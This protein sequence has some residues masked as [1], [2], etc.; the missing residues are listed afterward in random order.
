[1]GGESQPGARTTGR[2]PAPLSP[3]WAARGSLSLK[4][5]LSPITPLSQFSASNQGHRGGRGG[6]EAPVW[7]LGLAEAESMVQR[8]RGCC[9]PCTAEG[10]RWPQAALGTHEGE[11]KVADT[12]GYGE[13]PQASPRPCRHEAVGPC[14]IL[15]WERPVGVSVVLA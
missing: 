11:R 9:C 1:M 12:N 3:S 5:V 14:G 10:T 7:A 4:L 15:H 13:G 6:Y 2:Q 8:C